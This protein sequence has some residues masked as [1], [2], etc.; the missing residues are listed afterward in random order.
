MPFADIDVPL[1]DGPLHATLAYL[2]RD[3]SSD[4]GYLQ[5]V[6]SMA[7]LP[8]ALLQGMEQRYRAGLAVWPAQLAAHIDAP[9]A[10][11]VSPRSSRPELIEPYLQ[12]MRDKFPVAVDLTG[13]FERTGEQRAGEGATVAELIAATSYRP[14]GDERS[15]DA[16]VIVDDVVAEGKSAAAVIALLRTAGVP[17]TAKIRIA[18]PLW[19]GTAGAR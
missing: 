3:L 7:N 2:S 4:I 18:A 10:A 15:L 11:I 8:P 16:I 14:A 17:E 9:V 19:L 1:P 13:S 5:R 12:A 6:R